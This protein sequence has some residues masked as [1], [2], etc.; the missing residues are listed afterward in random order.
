MIHFEHGLP[1][2]ALDRFTLPCGLDVIVDRDPSV[3]QVC[4]SIWYR[5]GSSDERPELTG[6]AHL[7][8]H[9]FKNSEHMP[10]HHYEVLRKAGASDANA[11]TSADRTAYH[12]V[13][14]S[15]EVAPTA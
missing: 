5:A 10:A 2:F 14:P 8:E 9:M 4:A 6:F 3:P 15:N 7:F 1:R 12:E 11:S 13:V